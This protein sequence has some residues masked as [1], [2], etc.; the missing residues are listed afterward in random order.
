MFYTTD[1][2]SIDNLLAQ[3]DGGCI[4]IDS[5]IGEYKSFN[6]IS[7]S[8]RKRRSRA[9]SPTTVEETSLPRNTTGYEIDEEGHL[10]IGTDAPSWVGSLLPMRC[11]DQMLI[12]RHSS[13]RRC[14]SLRT[15]TACCQSTTARFGGG[16]KSP[17]AN[18]QALTPYIG[19][20]M[21]I[22]KTTLSFL[23]METPTIFDMPLAAP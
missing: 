3:N 9:R 20:I 5:S 2:C 6:V 11:M 16:T 7:G 19:T 14:K 12:Y 17:K 10:L 15:R 21:S 22:S 4:E 18:G 8:Y 13:T 1:D 23:G